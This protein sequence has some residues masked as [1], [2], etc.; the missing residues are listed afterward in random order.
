MYYIHLLYSIINFT[1]NRISQKKKKNITR[2]DC[3][4]EMLLNNQTQLF[5][6]K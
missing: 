1:Y 6:H 5:K 3:N 2:N 4:N